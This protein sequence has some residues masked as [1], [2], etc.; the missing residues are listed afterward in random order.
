MAELACH[1]DH[2]MPWL[3]I[4]H[5]AAAHARPQSEHAEVLNT[6]AGSGPFLSQCGTIR[7]VFKDYRRA[8]PVFQFPSHWIVRPARQVSGGVQ[9]AGGEINNSRNTNA[10]SQQLVAGT[11]FP[12]K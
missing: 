10:N 6:A 2:P 11:I 12:N 4:D 5:K 7:V 8:Q 1:A 9:G 3:A